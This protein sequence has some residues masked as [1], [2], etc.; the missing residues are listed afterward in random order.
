MSTAA[1]Q[2]RRF[3]IH[4]VRVRL[5]PLEKNKICGIATLLDPRFKNLAF[6]NNENIAPHILSIQN[7]IREATKSVDVVVS[8]PEQVN[9]NSVRFFNFMNNRLVEEYGKQKLSLDGD[10]YLSLFT[11]YL[12]HEPI[13]DEGTDV[14][15]FW[16][17]RESSSTILVDIAKDALIVCGSSVAS[18][19]TFSGMGNLI[20]D[21]QTRLKE[22]N[23]AMSMFIKMNDWLNNVKASS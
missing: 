21:K 10:R 8:M 17:K 5:L 12:Q 9:E 6:V 22:T 14:I 23:I 20:A 15:K 16:S 3:A 11:Q 19:Q 4:R 7:R 18:E 1:V 13:A 2:L